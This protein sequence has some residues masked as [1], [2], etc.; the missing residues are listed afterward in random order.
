M[1]RD[2]IIEPGSHIETIHDPPG[3]ESRDEGGD[4]AGGAGGAEG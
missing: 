2:R 1:E 3:D 4:S